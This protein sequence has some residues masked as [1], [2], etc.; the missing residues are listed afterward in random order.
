MILTYRDLVDPGS[1]E[2]VRHIIEPLP[3]GGVRTF[4]YVDGNPNKERID[5][6]IADGDTLEPA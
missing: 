5:G 3:D 4:P 1:G 6:L 2:T